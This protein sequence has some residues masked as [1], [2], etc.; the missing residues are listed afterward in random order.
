V[1]INKVDNMW[2]YVI[3]AY[4]LFWV[5]V[6]GLGGLASLVFHVSPYVMRWVT[7]LCSW[8]P[9]IVLWLMMRQLMPNTTIKAFYKKVFKEK[10]KFS[11]IL[12]GTAAVVG[13]FLAAV[14]IL[15]VVEQT[16]MTAQLH[17]VPAALGSNILFTALQGPSGEESGWRGYLR[18]EMES[19]YGFLK[20]S[21][22]L[23]LVWAFWHMPLWFV[24]SEFSGGQLIIYIA[25]V[26]VVLTAFTL[27]IS[28]CMKKCNNLFLAFW[29]HFCFNF[30]LSFLIGD[31]YFFAIF[32]SL[33]V[34]AAVGFTAIYLKQIKVRE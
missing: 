2:K 31:V 20:G 4:L 7:V 1:K 18:Q 26:V 30:A 13:I 10:I 21:I 27:I 34:A 28:V 32:A 17:F 3:Y 19:R 6:L 24:A 29:M 33:Y 23:G 16:E 15:A 9:T 12:V 14:F 8:S 5:M 11:I 22:I 25:S